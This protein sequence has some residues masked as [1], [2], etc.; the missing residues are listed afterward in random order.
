MYH[1]VEER[2]DPLRNFETSTISKK[3]SSPKIEAEVKKRSSTVVVPAEQKPETSVPKLTKAQSSGKINKPKK[4]IFNLNF[5]NFK[6][7]SEDV[8]DSDDSQTPTPISV[9]PMIDGT[10]ST[11]V[12][13]ADLNYK[14][15]SKYVGDVNQ[16]GKVIY[17]CLIFRR[18]MARGY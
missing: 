11:S 4:S 12:S 16:Y 3:L 13:T 8:G 18:N 14:D 9:K 6:S 1:N 15:G 17:F 5:F 7:Q 10:E 2:D